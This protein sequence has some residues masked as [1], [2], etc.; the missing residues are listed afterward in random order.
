MKKSFLGFLSAKDQINISIS[1]IYI[2]LRLTSFHHYF[3]SVEG[4]FTGLRPV[5]DD[6]GEGYVPTDEDIL[7]NR[8]Q[9]VPVVFRWEYGGKEVYISGS[10]N[11]WKTRIPL[12]MRY[13]LKQKYSSR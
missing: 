4:T 6:G 3:S 8:K 9:T 5:H 10:F 11:D 13:K 1:S 7:I 2:V 12:T